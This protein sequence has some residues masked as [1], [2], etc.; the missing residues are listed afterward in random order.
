VAGIVNERQAGKRTASEQIVKDSREALEAAWNHDKENREAAATDLAF[1]AGDQWPEQVRRER[2]AE[3]RPML[4]INRLPQFLRQVT[5]DIRQADI[6]IKAAP[7]DDNSDPKLAK[8]FNGLIRQIQYQSGAHHVYATAAEHQAGCGIGWFRITTEYADDSAFDQELRLE[9]IPHPLS[10]YCDPAAVKPDRSDAMW[11]LVTEMVPVETFK[12]RFPKAA[13]EAVDRPS[14]GSSSRLYWTTSD[15]VRIAEYWIKEPYEKTL[16]LTETGETIDIT[17]FKPAGL[18]FM[19]RVVKTR[20]QTAYKVKMYLVSGSEVLDGPH[21][22][23]GKFIP[24][25][26]VIGAEIPLDQKTYRYGVIRYARD[27]Q[28]LYNYYRTGVAEMLALAPKSPYLVT[29]EM[30]SDPAIKSIW[31]TAN[32]KNRPYLP[33]KPDPS[34]PSGP[35]REHPPE[36]PAS[37]MQEAQVAADDM[38]ATTGIFD[39]GLGNRSNET[40]GR[41]ILARQREGDIANYHFSDNLEQ[42]LQHAGRILIDLI[43]KIYD[44]QRV[45]R[46]L[47]EDDSEEFATINQEIMGVDGVPVIFNDL[48]QARFDVRVTIGPSYSTKRMETA[49]AMLQFI[50]AVPAAGQV[51]PDLVAKA[52]DF[53]G[54]EEV[55]KRLRNTI[56]PQ[57]LADPDDPESQPPPPPDPMQDPVIASEVRLKVAQAEKAEA[58]AMKAKLEAA[59]LEQAGVMPQVTDAQVVDPHEAM[60]KEATARKAMVD[61][62]TAEMALAEKKGQVEQVQLENNQRNRMAEADEGYKAELMNVMRALT[63]PKRVIRDQEGRAIGVEPVIP[64]PEPMQPDGMA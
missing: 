7:V 60:M 59:Q 31:D 29:T 11:M 41:A 23:P 28:Q 21:E 39:A 37:L 33:Y 47:G 15:A 52:L 36:M 30:L 2:E 62:E 14:D 53:P 35:K 40:S 8:I 16:G 24:L 55:A 12:K 17:G 34:M 61:A 46:M 1:L 19:P 49:D 26:P 32:K 50:Q 45:I 18:A 63:A 4:T 27:P 13:Q 25:V 44:N 9:H 22:W 3:G 58:D 48:S 5:N 20:K 57:V 56:P 42:S 51:A 64:Q 43:P 10:V 6:A 38:K 54:A